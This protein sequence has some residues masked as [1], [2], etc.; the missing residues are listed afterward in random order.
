[1]IV[2]SVD[3]T[4]GHPGRDWEGLDVPGGPKLETYLTRSVV[5]AIDRRYRTLADRGHRAL[6]G[7][8]GG[9]FAA[10]NI[11]L[12]RLD[13]FRALL[14]AMPYDVPDNRKR[15]AED[16]ALLAANTPRDSLRTR[17]FPQPAAAILTAGT[18]ATRRRRGGPPHRG[19]VPLPRRPGG[20]PHRGGLRPHLAHGPGV[21]AVP[22]GVRGRKLRTAGRVAPPA[23]QARLPG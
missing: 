20:G 10:L 3:L 18:G 14:L 22:A 11:G 7:M 12:H 2:V 8:S 21:A 5:P 17:S 6:G 23:G 15:L 9:A 13:A 19:G 4:A 1:M 16:P